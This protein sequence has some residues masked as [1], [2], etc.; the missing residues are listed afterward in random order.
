LASGSEAR[1]ACRVLQVGGRVGEEAVHVQGS[2]L[3]DTRDAALDLPTLLFAAA[4]VESFLG[5]VAQRAAGVVRRAQSCGITVQ[6]SASSPVLGA[7][8]DALAHRM[9]AVQYEIDDGPCLTCLRR[10]APVSVPDIHSDQRWPAFARRGAQEG[11]GSS[12][13]VPLAVQGK[14]VGALNLYSRSTHGLS[15]ADSTRATEFAR[16]AAAVVALAAQR[17]DHELREH[18]LEN[19]LRSRSIIDQAMG[20]LM[21]QAHV[22]AD[23]AFEMLRRRSQHSNTKLRDVAA[24]II[25]DAMRHR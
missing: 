22:S 3:P 21:G 10:G 18:H 2:G 13:S 7:T 23:E 14:T 11:A 24:T 25:V 6:G 16:H 1:S 20:V 4:E 8:T 9:D 12:L 15:E 5:E 17:A 19:A